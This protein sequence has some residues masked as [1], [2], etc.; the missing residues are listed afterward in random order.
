MP[1]RR[2]QVPGH[3]LLRLGEHRVAAACLS[4]AERH[5]RRV[6]RQAVRR[7]QELAV[8]GQD[9]LLQEPELGA[10]IDAK[11]IGHDAPHVLVGGEGVG[12]PAAAVQ[13]QHQLRVELLLQGMSRDQLAQFC[14]DLTVPSQMQIGVDPRDQRLQP[15]VV[16][17]GDLTE[18]QQ[19]GRHVGEGLAP[20][21]RE[22]VAQQARRLR[23]GPGLGGGVAA[24]GEHAELADIEVAVVDLD[25]VTR[26]PG[27]DQAGAGRAQRRAQALNGTVQRAPRPGRE[28]AFPQRLAQSV[29]ADHP[30][31]AQQQ[32]RQQHPLPGCRHGYLSRAITD[33]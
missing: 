28:L 1:R 31:G 5:R 22:R 7:R 2:G 17:G 6:G 8:G 10:R 11:L 3:H 29:Q 33:Q 19:L 4:R 27:L 25:Q 15:L 23:P 16:Q 21:Q 26:R 20:P 14:H 12:L 9:P 18:P 32:R 30:P 24:R 13:A